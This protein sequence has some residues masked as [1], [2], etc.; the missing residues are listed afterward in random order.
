MAKELDQKSPKIDR[1]ISQIE[2]GEIKIPPLQRPFVWKKEQVIELLESIYRDYPIGSILLWETNDPLPAQRNV[3]GFCIPDKEPSYPFYYVLDGQQ[4]LSSLYG[5][6]CKDRT[7]DSDQE[8]YSIDR[9]VFDIFFDLER[10][11]FVHADDCQNGRSYL[12]LKTLFDTSSFWKALEPLSEEERKEAVQLQS[13]FSNYEVPEII[14]KKRELQ[15]VGNIFERVN[16]TG[17]RLDLFDLMVAV[18]WAKDFHLR[19]EFS[20]VQSALDRKHFKGVKEKVLLQCLAGIIGKSSKTR[21]ITS[22]N[23]QTVRDNLPK[24]EESLKKAVDFLSTEL[25]VKSIQLLPHIHQIV[26]LTYFFSRVNIPNQKQKKI[27]KQWF[28][29][30]S[31]S[32]RYS[33]ST[34]THIDEDIASFDAVLDGGVDAFKKLSY[35]VTADQLRETKFL[36]SSPYSRAFVVLLASSHP[37]NLVNGANVDTGEALPC[38]NQREYHHIFPRAFLSRSGSDL[39]NINSICNFCILP[40]DS[41]KVISDKAPSEYFE[42]IIPQEEIQEILESN[43]MPVKWALYKKDD[44]GSFL[45]ERARKIIDYL[46]A[47]LV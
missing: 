39:D 18:T 41:N 38:F 6:F 36:R 44:Y 20:R 34:D 32:K 5:V 40:A 37:K 46:D 26:P 7:V 23:A 45:E 4:R 2:S 9:E 11:V 21:V 43:L 1:L 47:Q 25:S 33:A 27:I 31:F 8:D 30:T 3:A 19:T 17:T 13:K 16:N 42:S 12:D 24:L 29:K 22:L 28:W 10:Q 15:E 35:S 14:T